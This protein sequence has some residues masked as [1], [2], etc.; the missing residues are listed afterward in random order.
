ML[1]V[2]IY[3]YCQKIY[4]LAESQQQREHPFY[5]DCGGEYPDHHTIKEFRGKY[6]PPVIAEVFQVLV[7]YL[8]DATKI[9]VKGAI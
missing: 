4:T 5:A 7:E 3:G 1:K 6:A 9:E 8:V 2:Q